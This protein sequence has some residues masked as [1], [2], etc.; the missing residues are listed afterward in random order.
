[1][2]HRQVTGNRSFY[3]RARQF[4]L[5]NVLHA[6][7]PPHRLALGVAIA[8]FVTFTPFIGVQMVLAVFLAWL[9]RA[10]KAVGVPLVWIS[11]P[12]TIPIIYFPCYMVGCK[13][14]GMSADASLLSSLAHPPAGWLERTQFY[15]NKVAVI[16]SPL[17]LGCLVV[18]SVVGVGSYYVTYLAIRT[19]RLKRLG[20]LMPP[21]NQDSPDAANVSTG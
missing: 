5:H 8:M 1:M 7:D 14:L 11:N 18:A 20:Q 9:F 13:L 3:G 2:V 17:L 6:D 21:S 19:Y 10:N 4:I 15:W 12:A 16:S